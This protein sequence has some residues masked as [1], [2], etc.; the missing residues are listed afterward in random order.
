MDVPSSVNPTDLINQFTILLNDRTDEFLLDIVDFLLDICRRYPSQYPQHSHLVIMDV[1][2]NTLSYNKNL[3][4]ILELE[5]LT[6]IVND[7][8][9]QLLQCAYNAS[10]QQSTTLLY[11]KRLEK[12]IQLQ[13]LCPKKE[14]NDNDDEIT[15]IYLAMPHFYIVWC[16]LSYL[17]LTTQ[18]M[19]DQFLIVSIMQFLLNLESSSQHGHLLYIALLP[20][21]QTLAEIQDNPNLKKLT[22]NLISDINNCSLSVENENEKITLLEKINKDTK[23][24][25]ITGG[26][27]YMISHLC[28][29]LGQ[30]TDQYDDSLVHY[31]SL[32]VFSSTLAILFCVPLLFN[33]DF[34]IRHTQ[35]SQVVHLSTHVQDLGYLKFSILLILLHL[36]RHPVATSDTLLYI[37]KTAIPSLASV[38][39]PITTTK[40]LQITLSLVH[41]QQNSSSMTQ[42]L[43]HTSRET[44]MI[45]IGIKVLTQLCDTNP[46]IWQEL[47]KVIS[48]WVLKR[49]SNQGRGSN[50][51]IDKTGTIQVELS[52]LTTMR[53][54]CISHPQEYGSDILPMLISL[55]QTAQY[56]HVGSLSIMMQVMCACIQSGLT[57]PRSMWLVAISHIARFAM[58]LSTEQSSLLLRRLCGFFKIVGEKDENSEIYIEFKQTILDD[59]LVHLIHSRDEK[60]KSS[61]LD[62]LS[63]FSPA[64]IATLIPDKSKQYLNEILKTINSGITATSYSKILVALMNHELDHMRRGYFSTEGENKLSSNIGQQQEEEKF[65]DGSMIATTF[66]NIWENAHVSP[67]LRSGYATS[68]L[69]GVKNNLDP[70]LGANTTETIMK[71]KWY[72]CMMTSIVDI[73][74]IDHLIVRVA[75]FGAWK[76]FF[77]AI[78]VGNEGDVDNR[79]LLLLKDLLTRLDKSTVPG[80]TCNIFLALTGMVSKLYEIIPSCATK[81]AV[82]L[83]DV[84]TSKYLAEDAS[85]FQPLLITSEEVQ[86]AARI[87]LGYISECIVINDKMTTDILNHLLRLVTKCRHTK[88]ELDLIHFSS[89]F[90]A[91]RLTSVLST[92]PTKSSTIE[93]LSVHGNSE[94]I[95]YCNH[96]DPN[97]VSDSTCLGIMMGWASKM[98]RDDMNTVYD[99]A[100]KQLENYKHGRMVNQGLL[101]GAPWV[102]AYGVQSPDDD[103][104]NLLTNVASRA[105]KDEKMI[106]NI[107]HF[108]I[109][110]SRLSRLYLISSNKNEST[111]D[112]NKLFLSKVQVISTDDSASRLRI[113]A[114]LCL[115]TLLGADYLHTPI[116]DY[117]QLEKEVKQ[118]NSDTR[119]PLV[120]ILMKLAGI[121][122]NQSTGNLKCGRI[123]AV[124]CGEII[125]YIE[126]LKKSNS[127]VSIAATTNILTSAEPKTYGRLNNNTS[128]LRALFDSLSDTIQNYQ[129]ANMVLPDHVAVYVRILLSSLRDIDGPLPSVNWFP[130]LNQISKISNEI[131]LL[132]FTA[133]SKHAATSVS[134]SEYVLSE[135]G[136]GLTLTTTTATT[137]NSNIKESSLMD[138]FVDEAGIGKLLDLSGLTNQSNQAHIK[139]RGMDAV[140]KKMSISDVR[141]LELLEAYI[142]SF[143]TFSKNTQKIFLTTV[144]N[145]LPADLTNID[146]SKQHY[147][148]SIQNLIKQYITYTLL[149]DVNADMETICLSVNISILSMKTLL[150]NMDIKDWFA[151]H[152][153]TIYNRVVAMMELCSLNKVPD[154]QKWMTDVILQLTLLLGKSDT[155]TLDKKVGIA[156]WNIISDTLYHQQQLQISK[157]KNYTTESLGWT[158][159]LLDILIIING[160][161]EEESALCIKYALRTVIRQILSK[162]WS[163]SLENNCDQVF[164]LEDIQLAETNYLIVYSISEAKGSDYQK[165]IVRRI[166]KII[167]LFS[168]KKDDES[169]QVKSFFIQVLRD[170][171]KDAMKNQEESISSFI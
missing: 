14:N 161:E 144:K 9:Y 111:Q 151:T 49:K 168:D 70:E 44:T 46:R 141:A 108:D 149:D 167:E 109:P 163:Q 5:D 122:N 169:S 62:A 63:A 72:R 37:L 66:F 147:I 53:E 89:G 135:L 129:K 118:Y 143:T 52:I 153:S 120:D 145:H 73:S 152:T 127:P 88:R 138:S 36:M 40:T 38:N 104:L 117:E 48:D 103:T 45:S 2:I 80:Q 112:F 98:N 4:Q 107:Y 148:A 159:R 90:A 131:R 101:L 60:V 154:I 86:Y 3:H 106:Q 28:K 56:V 121:E 31:S 160:M 18:T 102:C 34:T 20:L 59:Y 13:E 39:D 166:F 162:L 114:A 26:M 54:L 124:V 22:L 134:L 43:S 115:G 95:N 77:N 100:R 155:I 51:E 123:S 79:A 30:H 156:S 58:G 83:I 142:K 137:I 71:T 84:I 67:G 42:A 157:E 74:L 32:T 164:T 150:Q 76:S 78:L 139:R 126:R 170:C 15:S 33:D 82:Q 64:D 29:Y 125:D 6:I 75:S 133:A 24:Y 94:L 27:A 12:V 132:C 99:F 91:A 81:C 41:G 128:Y 17:L 116:A 65:T 85:N 105:S 130:L 92:W 19:D 10:L 57:E 11:L 55:L 93:V 1:L 158:L 136:H 69:Y 47:K 97:A 146:E 171:P 96:D 68:I 113:P 21:F 119:K 61:A 23:F 16:S 110:L 35:L 140:T 165:Q 8:I 7:L 87:C 25:E 50:I